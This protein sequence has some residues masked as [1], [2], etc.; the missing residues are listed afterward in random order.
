VKGSGVYSVVFY[1]PVKVAS[2]NADGFG[3]LRYVPAELLEPL[4][5]EPALIQ[6]KI[7]RAVTDSQRDITCDPGRPG[8]TN[9]AT[10]YH[11]LSGESFDEIKDKYE[12]KGYAPFK[13]DLADL[14]NIG[15]LGSHG[16]DHRWEALRDPGIFKED[17]KNSKEIV[18]T[19][20]Y[21]SSQ[22]I[23]DLAYKSVKNNDPDRLEVKLGIDKKLLEIKS[24]RIE[25]AELMKNIKV[26]SFGIRSESIDIDLYEELGISNRIKSFEEKKTKLDSEIQHI[27]WQTEI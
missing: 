15:A 19:E 16:H 27:N 22:D 21:R 12:G 10:I 6:K 2:F 1:L 17:Y 4:L 7:K 5:D 3:C 8:V 23:L 20:N 24:I 26:G 14:N 18:L 9:L 25:L 11:C 13:S